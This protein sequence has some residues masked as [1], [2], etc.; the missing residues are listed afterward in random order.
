M[1]L[2]YSASIGGFLDSDI[3]SELPDDVVAISKETHSYLLDGQKNGAKIVSSGGSPKLSFPPKPTEEEVNSRLSE[4]QRKKR[5]SYLMKSDWT[6]VADAPVDQAAWATY[7]Q[8]LRDVTSQD[9]FP[10][11][12]TWPVA[13]Q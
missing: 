7:R 3:W 5:D 2:Y 11:E 8:E 9:T 13:P 6:Q 4:S 12:V 10:S 1:S